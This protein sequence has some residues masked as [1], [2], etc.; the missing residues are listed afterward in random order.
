MFELTNFKRAPP[1][2]SALDN[3][4]V[5]LGRVTTEMLKEVYNYFVSNFH[6][7]TTDFV[8]DK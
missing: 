6:C 7:R 2:D 1:I 3:L 8:D 4:G 5:R